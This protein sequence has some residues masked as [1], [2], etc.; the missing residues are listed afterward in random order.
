M[1]QRV[2]SVVA[3][4]LALLAGAAIERARAADLPAP[5]AQVPP[6]KAPAFVP[7]RPWWRFFTDGEWYFEFGSDKE[8]WTNPNIHVSQPALGNNFTIY[9]VTGHDAP[10]GSGEAPQFNIRV[11]R[12]IT[13]NWGVELS[14]DHSKFIT[15]IGQIAQ[16]TGTIGGVPVNGP[17]A[18]DNVFFNEQLHNGAN[19]F[20]AEAVYRYPLYGRT[21]ETNSLA[22]IGKA[23]LGIMLP[24]TSDII[25]GNPNN[26]GTKSFGNLV[27]TSSGWWQLNGWTAGAEIG[28][29]YTFF[30]PFYLEL[31]NKVAYSGFWNLPAFEGTL[32]QSMWMDEIILT[33]GFT[34]D[35]TSAHPVW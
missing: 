13:E 11:G 22:A 10:T 25:L 19:H 14:L 7:D 1:P 9:N 35:G 31:T 17:R 30:K 4:L 18:L 12:F 34:Y 33:F 3:G 5:A 16:V 24:H 6:A 28:L 8:W 26:V 32:Q 20:M 15:D 29:R 21:N 27:G 2:W 23:G